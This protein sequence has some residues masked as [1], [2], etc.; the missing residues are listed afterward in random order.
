MATIS[1]EED[2]TPAVLFAARVLRERLADGGLPLGQFEG[3]T[4]LVSASDPQ[5]VTLRVGPDR[6]GISHGI[7]PDADRVVEVDIDGPFTATEPAALDET[8]QGLL[9][10]MCGPLPP[11]TQSL[12][13]FWAHGSRLP[14]MPSSIEVLCSD[15]TR[16]V[17]GS[18]EP[19][20]RVAGTPEALE[21][22]FYGVDIFLY[23]VVG[24][25]I[26]TDGTASHLSVL[27]GASWN[28]RFGNGS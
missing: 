4:V 23:A 7:A 24:G 17:V 6:I 8:A 2:P 12:E 9:G 18:G 14:G 26:T 25:A 3:T 15:G 21:R 13:A 20:Y 5:A 28:A 16:A 11:W 19:C 10:L 27:T 1:V 22:V